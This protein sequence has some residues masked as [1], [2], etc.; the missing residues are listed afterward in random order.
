MTECGQ[1]AI[2]L[3]TMSPAD[4]TTNVARRRV[5][6]RCSLPSGHAG[7]HRDVEHNEQWERDKPGVPMI[8]RDEGEE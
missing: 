2:L 8:F 1:H 6:L 5:E 7:P 3:I 4:T